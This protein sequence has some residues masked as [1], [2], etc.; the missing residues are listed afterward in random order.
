MFQKLPIKTLNNLWAVEVARIL[1][2]I[3]IELHYDKV[4]E[5]RNEEVD[6]LCVEAHQSGL[7]RVLF[8]HLPS[9]G[10]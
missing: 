2:A 4:F 8:F 9:Q 10:A 3:R 1:A 6:A 5:R 7:C